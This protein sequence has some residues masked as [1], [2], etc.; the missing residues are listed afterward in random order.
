[1]LID[2]FSRVEAV[3]DDQNEK[4][5]SPTASPSTSHPGRRRAARRQ[6]SPTQEL[7]MSEGVRQRMDTRMIQLPIITAPT[8]D[9]DATSEEEP[10]APWR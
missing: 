9:E 4:A 5:A 10:P 7:D 8:T 1:M 6:L 3:E 2:L